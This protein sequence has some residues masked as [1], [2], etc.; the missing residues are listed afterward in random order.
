MSRERAAQLL[1]I[2]DR[3]DGEYKEAEVNEALS[4]REEMVPLLIG[5]LEEVAEQSESFLEFGRFAHNYAV[6]LLAHFRE[7]ATHLPIIRAFTLPGETLDAVWGEVM[8]ES[9]A[10]LLCRTAGS[11]YRAVK[12]LALDQEADTF[13]RAAA[14]EALKL[15]VAQGDLARDEALAFYASLF[16]DG[17]AAA[18]ELFWTSLVFE[19]LD[20][21]PGELIGKIRDLYDKGLVTEEFA[22]FDKIEKIVDGGLEQALAKLPGRLAQRS[23]DDV[24]EY[25]SWFGCFHDADA[26]WDDP[27]YF[28]AGEA[29]LQKSQQ[30]KK[31]KARK[32]RKKAKAAKRKN[33]K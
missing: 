26:D 8:T 17:L 25:I 33:R 13:V 9:L 19:L 15:G 4:L 1:E 6:P 11:D 32:H 7:P 29:S 23:P 27:E 22:S 21:Y 14:L 2:F 18:D 3:F 30:C 12:A 20:L 16:D 10:A 5:L 31:Q 28:S 24:H